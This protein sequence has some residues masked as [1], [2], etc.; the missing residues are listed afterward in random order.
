MR[1]IIAGSRDVCEEDVMFAIEN[2]E[3]KS[4][5][6]VVVSGGAKGADSYGEKWAMANHLSIKQFIPDWKAKG[7]SAGPQR[8]A[9][10]SKNADGL[11]AVWDGES[12]GTKN[13]IEHATKNGLRILIF[14]TSTRKFTHKD[15]TGL[16][17]F[18]WKNY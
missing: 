2:C 10:M 6:K 3:W 1:V 14:N 17:L 11:I 12:K 4:K 15:A 7:K 18:R 9:E 16:V 5:I 8:N 13:M